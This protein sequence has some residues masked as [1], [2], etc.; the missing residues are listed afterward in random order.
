LT[1]MSEA[2]RIE[3]LEQRL[4]Y[5]QSLFNQPTNRIRALFPLTEHQARVLQALM[6]YE[7]GT[8]AIM[9]E[10]VW[11]GEQEPYDLKVIAVQIC[12]M[13]RKLPD[14][15]KIESIRAVGYRLSTSSRK[16]LLELTGFNAHD[17]IEKETP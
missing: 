13:R 15:V 11:R 17:C 4:D 10:M 2:E 12:A 6:V 9:E 14:W 16:R 7:I 3:E 5:Y 8:F 1:G